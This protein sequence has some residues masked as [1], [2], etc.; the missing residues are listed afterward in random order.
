[1]LGILIILALGLLVCSGLV[2]FLKSAPKK[3]AGIPFWVKAW[4]E[5]QKGGIKKFASSIWF[6]MAAVLW[7][8]VFAVSLV[9][10]FQ[11]ERLAIVFLTVI[12][13]IALILLVGGYATLRKSKNAFFVLQAILTFVVLYLLIPDL[14]NI[15]PSAV[16]KSVGFFDSVRLAVQ[17]FY[18]V[19][20]ALV[21]VIVAW[22]WNLAIKILYLTLL[23]LTLVNAKGFVFPSAKGV[24]GNTQGVPVEYA[25]L[26]GDPRSSDGALIRFDTRS[27]GPHAILLGQGNLELLPGSQ[28]VWEKVPGVVYKYWGNQKHKERW[29][30][31]SGDISGD[32]MPR[33][34]R[35]YEHPDWFKDRFL[36]CGAFMYRIGDGEWCAPFTWSGIYKGMV[37]LP[38]GILWVDINTTRCRE[39]DDGTLYYDPNHCEGK[40]VVR[41]KVVNPSGRPLIR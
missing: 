31:V 32:G 26:E 1:M 8:A 16:H 3:E 5:I 13:P 15:L 9:N 18:A 23:V 36:P 25:I 14:N 30:S 34:P 6:I 12:V 33:Y 4:P 10:H 28:L 2:Y 19:V 20:I 22:R 39:Q 11:A 40:V 7:V 37:S 29:V 41:L 38:G 27:Q 21:A 17:A 24:P 35:D